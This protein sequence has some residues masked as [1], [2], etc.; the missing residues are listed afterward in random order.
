MFKNGKFVKIVKK[1]IHWK[2]SI[3]ILKVSIFKK[4]KYIK[5]INNI[6]IK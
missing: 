5:I 1:H 3:E 4:G 2:F 6:K